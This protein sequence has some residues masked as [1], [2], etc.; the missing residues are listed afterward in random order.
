M[1]K[2]ILVTGATG[3][4]GHYVIQQLIQSN[5]HVIATSSNI[6]KASKAIWFNN[7]TYLP[8]NLNTVDNAINYY[9]YFN[10]PDVCIHLAWPGLPNYKNEAHVL[11]YLPQQKVLLNNLVINGLQDITITGT[12]FEY[13]MQSG[14]LKEDMACHPSNPYAL[15]KNDLRIYMEEK[16]AQHKI[17]YKWLRLF[18]MYGK[19]QNEKSLFSQLDLAIQN[20]AAIF[21]MSGGEQTRD[22]LPVEKVAAYIIQ[23]AMQKK[24][25]GIINCCSG[26]PITIKQLV[27]NYL[28]Q[29][30]KNIPLNLG[31]YPYTDY[32]AM[33]FWG[34]NSKLLLINK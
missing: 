31:Y 19:G 29:I 32:E 9:Q 21:N 17:N 25:Q 14:C 6:E 1:N 5:Y 10:Q 8:L 2:K 22:F 16:S 23:C 12:C 33:H 27:Q 34:D 18:Y 26:Q 4:V 28:K 30:N 24:I 13:G 7:V 11:Q 3:F 20:D 15:A